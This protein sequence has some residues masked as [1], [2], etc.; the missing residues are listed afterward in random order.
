VRVVSGAGAPA[1]G[2]TYPKPERGNKIKISKTDTHKSAPPPRTI[3]FPF[4][5]IP[6]S[7]APPLFARVATSLPACPASSRR[8]R[9]PLPPP[10]LPQQPSE[11]NS[12]AGGERERERGRE[13]GRDG[14]VPDLS[15][16]ALS[17]RSPPTDHRPTPR[18][19][20]PAQICC[21]S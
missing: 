3:S 11:V 2:G 17:A 7:S 5:S 6:P 4:Y 16:A 19:C 8:R 12:S 10:P 15:R 18:S 20:R 1:V 14:R 21:C 13:R 9:G